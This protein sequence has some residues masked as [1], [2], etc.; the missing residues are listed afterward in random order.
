MNTHGEVVDYNSDKQELT[1]KY[2][3]GTVYDYYP[4]DFLSYQFLSSSHNFSDQLHTVLRS[5][6]TV[7][8]RRVR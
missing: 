6:S 5:G 2:Q 7:G 3:G 4:V 8:V 1:V